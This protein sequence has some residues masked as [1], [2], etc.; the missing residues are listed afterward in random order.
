M[1]GPTT[2]AEL[3]HLAEQQLTELTSAAGTS[4]ARTPAELAAG[5]PAVHRAGRQ[6]IAALHPDEYGHA[7]P[8]AQ[9]RASAG[10]PVAAPARSPVPQL[11]RAAELISAAADLIASQERRALSAADRQADLARAARPLL[12]AAYLVARATVSDSMLLEPAVS[13]VTAARDWSALSPAG[14]L[15]PRA[16][17]LHDASTRTSSTPEG[18][19]DA[20][21]QT[22]NR[23]VA[24]WQQAV[25][26]A[27][28]QTAA[29]STD[30]Q[31]T[32]RTAGGLIAL[33][34][35]LLR[36][37]QQS[38]GP[39]STEPA[40]TVGD[41][42]A[43]GRSWNAAVASWGNL[44]TGGAPP[45]HALVTATAELRQAI[46]LLGR[47]GAH[48]A[49]PHVVRDRSESAAALAAARG[50]LIA[51]QSVAD[52]HAPLVS[53]LVRA[54]GLYL[55][56]RQLSP[57]VQNLPARLARH[58][59]P[60][61]ELEHRPLTEA[62]QQLPTTTS[63]ARLAYTALTGPASS[64]QRP[65]APQQQLEPAGHELPENPAPP[66]SENP[67]ATASPPDLGDQTLATRRW[68]Q[69]ARNL[70]PRLLSD[71]HWLALAGALD[72]V[73]L[74]GTDVEQTLTE[75]AAQGPLPDEHPART[76]HY[77]LIELCD[78]AATPNTTPAMLTRPASRTVTTPSLP[79]ATRPP[80][81][82]RG[83]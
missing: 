43:A 53:E 25:L 28:Q 68:Q 32:A 23:A 80:S 78:A 31:G 36:A 9:H 10:T 42:R 51:V 41:L 2:A 35:V 47:S 26:D 18:G 17:S 72:R 21:P 1:S 50:A 55:P 83:R 6:L 67:P 48:W 15:D 73:A 61:T 29:S 76:L 65:H 79:T 38:A 54:G 69:A 62:Y 57:T 81:P 60:A 39:Y 22:L 58:W 5:W 37:H 56:A 24:R 16:G 71:P 33:T 74:S 66:A 64:Y 52:L 49:P 40:R 34:L 59:L 45:D 82:S 7:T 11:A 14:H 77:R 19:P 63:I 8:P 30:L 44:R 4:R 75:T 20:L 27:A 3:L 46:R 12:A 13:A 70:D